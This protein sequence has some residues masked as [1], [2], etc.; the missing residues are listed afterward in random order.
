MD[1]STASD[2]ATQEIVD[3][4]DMGYAETIAGYQ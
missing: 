1:I 2:S 3:G 4:I